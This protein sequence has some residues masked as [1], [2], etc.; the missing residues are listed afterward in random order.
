M[1]EKKL[2]PIDRIIVHPPPDTSANE[3]KNGKPPPTWDPGKVTQP[4]E[5]DEEEVGTS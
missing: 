1:V 3:G 2:E 5:V 4:V